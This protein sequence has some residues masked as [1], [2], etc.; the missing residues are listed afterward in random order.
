MMSRSRL[1]PEVSDCIIDLLH[2][3]HKTLKVCCLVSKSWVPR[4]RK[5]L[6]AEVVLRS[7]DALEAWKQTFPDPVGSPGYY[8]R[9]LYISCP[10]VIFAAVVE[11]NGWIRAFFNVVRLRVRGARYL[12]SRFLPQLLTRS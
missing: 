10:Q 11:E 8:T 1:P 12:C 6:F 3:E 7:L 4:V 2:S 9:S 5:H